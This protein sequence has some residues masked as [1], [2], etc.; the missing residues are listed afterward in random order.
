MKLVLLIVNAPLV[1]YMK[2][3]KVPVGVNL[4]NPLPTATAKTFLLERVSLA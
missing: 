2:Y 1:P 3:N 4:V